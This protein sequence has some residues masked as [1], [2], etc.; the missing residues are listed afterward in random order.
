MTTPKKDEERLKRLRGIAERIQREI[1]KIRN[2]Q[3][4]REMKWL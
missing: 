3:V 2:R 1:V 4:V